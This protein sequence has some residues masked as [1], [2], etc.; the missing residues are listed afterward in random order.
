M[1]GL[2]MHTRGSRF[3]TREE[4]FALPTPES[5]GPRH[6]PVPFRDLI[7]SLDQK[8]SEFGWKIRNEDVDG[9]SRKSCETW[10][11]AAGGQRLFGVVDIVGDGLQVG[12][13]CTAS[14]GLRSSTNE[15]LAIKGVAGQ[16]VFV[17]DNLMM[18]GSEFLMRRKSTTFVS[19]MDLLQNGLE[20]FYHETG[21]LRENVGRLQNAR[22]VGSNMK[23][24]VFDLFA[25]RRTAR[26]AYEAVLPPKLLPQV[27]SNYL[28]PEETWT[29]CQP[30]TLWGLSNACTRAVQALK[31][32]SRFEHENAIGRHFVERVA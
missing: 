8:L 4:I 31:P 3:A 1:Q 24:E 18:S 5:M 20:K 16:G 25:P 23:K 32:Q 6:K 27:C 7:E 30:R 28:E 11:L 29:D 17:C 12:D 15:S 13:G 9:D 22:L 26:G 14:L 19:I 10:G 21:T 2:M